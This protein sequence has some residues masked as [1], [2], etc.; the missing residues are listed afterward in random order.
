MPHP[1]LVT[2]GLLT[3][4][5]AL[6][7]TVEPHLATNQ[8]LV[9]HERSPIE[10]VLGD[11][12]RLFATHFFVKA[13]VYFHSGYYPS[14][15]DGAASQETHL[16]TG[17]AGEA[18]HEEV[19]F[20][21][22]PRDLIDRFSRAFYPSTHSHLDEEHDD[23]KGHESHD[24]HD[25]HSNCKGEV[26]E[27]LPWLKLTAELDPNRVETYTVGAYWLRTRVGNAAQAET[28]LRDGLRA[29]PGSAAILFELGRIYYEFNHDF[30][31]ARNVWEAALKRWNAIE[32]TKSDPDNFL[33][34]QITWN[35][36]LLE[37]KS[38]DTRKAVD[39]LKVAKEV[40]PKPEAV[41]EKM[42]ELSKYFIDIPSSF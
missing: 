3:G 20:L 42:E 12:R 30:E 9:R 37:E 28:F 29:N 31:R 10:V 26:R 2:A 41:Q 22:K 24:D 36:A 15:F 39:Y 21:G 38:G 1:L 7:V 18:D 4:C 8:A 6:A 25:D 19:D 5:F 11:A 16:A 33:L 27:M 23:H 32:K 17:A 35:L 40:S 13:D 14:I 34:L